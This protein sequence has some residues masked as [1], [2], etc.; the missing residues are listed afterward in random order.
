[1]QPNFVEPVVQQS[2]LNVEYELA[3]NLSVTV[4]GLW[5]KGNHL[6]RTRDINLGN[7]APAVFT[8]SG[9][10]QTFTVNRYGT[11]PI[12]AFSRILQF[13]SSANSTYNGLIMEV[14]KRFARNFQFLGSYTWS[15]VI[16]DAPDATAVVPG[17]DDFKMLSDPLCDVCDRASSVNDQRHRF[18]VSGVWQM[19][20]AD[21]FSAIPKAVLGGWELSTI[22]SVQTGQPYTGLVNADLNSDGNRANDRAGEARNG[23]NLPTTWSL[24]P[25]LTKNIGLT[26][27]AHVQLLAEAFNIFNHFNVY[28]V[29]TTQY[30]LSGTTLIPQTT[31]LTAF[32]TPTN[33]PSGSV[34]AINLNGARVFQ[35]G[36]KVIF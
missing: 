15:H 16:D 34:A 19:H 30:A 13:E 25:R 9:T 24:D 32:R 6:Q 26:E 8:V 23:F 35:L 2:N 7:A 3:N 17:A 14:R 20:Y 18:V 22:F 10:G 12:P 1:M 4:G 29:R 28:N 33:A 27:R 11:R 31:G 36:A 21:G 5:V